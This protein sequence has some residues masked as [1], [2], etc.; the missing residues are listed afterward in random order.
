MLSFLQKLVSQIVSG[1]NTLDLKAIRSVLGELELLIVLK[2]R[3]LHFY[4]CSSTFIAF[5][6]AKEFQFRLRTSNVLK[7]SGS[8]SSAVTYYG[9]ILSTTS[10]GSL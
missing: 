8:L 9:N 1:D 10:K 4:K 2:K 7:I 3:T 6:N 5:E